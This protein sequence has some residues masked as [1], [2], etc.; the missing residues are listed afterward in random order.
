MEVLQAKEGGPASSNSNATDQASTSAAAAEPA[1]NA[2][3]ASRK[4]VRFLHCFTLVAALLPLS[5]STPVVRRVSK[6]PI[7][8]QARCSAQL[9]QIIPL[10]VNCVIGPSFHHEKYQPVPA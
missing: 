9:L 6:C 8:R 1:S 4:E 3:P 7:Q 2:P 10:R 5:A